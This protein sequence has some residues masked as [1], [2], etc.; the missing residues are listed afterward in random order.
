MK[1]VVRNGHYDAGKQFCKELTLKKVR[2]DKKKNTELMAMA[3]KNRISTLLE[4]EI[5]KNTTKRNK[6]KNRITKKIRKGRK[7]TKTN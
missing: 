5:K 6:L 2:E 1:N 3:I 4:D 7:E